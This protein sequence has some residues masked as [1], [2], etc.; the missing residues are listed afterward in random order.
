MGY[1]EALEAAGAVVELSD[2]FGSY[3][4]DWWALVT[5]GGRRF[6]VHGSYGSCSHCDAF[7]AEFGYSENDGCAEHRYDAKTDCAACKVTTAAYQTRLAE[8]G[9]GYLTG[10]EMTQ[11][12]AE[13]VASEH[14]EWDSDAQEMLDF[15]KANSID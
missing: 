3:Q 5:Y 8:F 10:G 6:W 7:Q 1:N 11:A 9:S 12:E 14:L 13:A 2:T 15:L 4:G